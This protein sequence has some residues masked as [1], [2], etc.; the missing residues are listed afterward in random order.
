MTWRTRTPPS[1]GDYRQREYFA[2]LP[3]SARL[4]PERGL[5]EHRWLERV[6][7]TEVFG[8]Y[9]WHTVRFHDCEP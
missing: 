7:V 1:N 8:A 5:I 4:L 2:W 3:V 9:H 6:T